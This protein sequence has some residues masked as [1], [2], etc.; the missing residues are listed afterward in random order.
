MFLFGKEVAKKSPEVQFR[1][2]SH[3]ILP[4]GVVAKQNPSL[5]QLPSNV[6]ISDQ[7]KPNDL[8][9]ARWFLYRGTSLVFEALAA[10]ARPLYAGKKAELSIDPLKN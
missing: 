7:G 4:F 5:K 9:Q 10:G 2:R 1:F 3:P 8:I 6:E